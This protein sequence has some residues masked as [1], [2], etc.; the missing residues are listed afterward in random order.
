MVS[1]QAYLFLI[2]AINGIIIGLVFDAFRILRK[3]FKTSDLITVIQDILFW[4]ITGTIILYSIFIFN[5][6]EIRFFMFVAIFLGAALYMLLLSQYIIKISVGVIDI[7]KKVI[8]FILKILAFPI[9]IISKT[10]KKP[11]LF[12]FIN[13]KK[14]IRQIISKTTKINLKKQKNRG[15]IKRK[16]E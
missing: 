16:V 1:N 10:I 13:V 5:D 15:K 4:I 6:G 8:K 7:F 11:I 14:I 12:C 9:K 2:F 3:S